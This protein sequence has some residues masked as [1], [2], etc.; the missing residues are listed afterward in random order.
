MMDMRM[1]IITPPEC[2]QD[3]SN[4]FAVEE[5]KHAR[6]ENLEKKNRREKANGQLSATVLGQYSQELCN[7]MEAHKDWNKTNA[8]DIVI[9]LLGVS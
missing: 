1:D 3:P 9:G 7:H 8:E 4:Q 5:W 2:P 6:K